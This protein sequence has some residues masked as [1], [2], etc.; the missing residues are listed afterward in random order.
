MPGSATTKFCFLKGGQFRF[1]LFGEGSS[2]LRSNLSVG[3]G[4]VWDLD[5]IFLLGEGEFG[6][7]II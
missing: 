6:T 2:G 7:S 3:E 1:F 4:R 5:E